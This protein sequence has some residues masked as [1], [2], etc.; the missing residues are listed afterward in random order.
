MARAKSS[1]A[2]RMDEVQQLINADLKQLGFKKSQR[3]YNRQTEPGVV[4]VIN[5]QMGRFE[6]PAGPSPI[7]PW[8]KPDMYGKFTVNLGIFVEEVVKTLGLKPEKFIS[9]PGCTIRRRLGSL[10][11]ADRRDYWWNLDDSATVIAQSIKSYL[12]SAGFEFLN[13]FS[14]RS[15]I[16]ADYI[17]YNDLDSNGSP[18][19]RLD[20]GIMLAAR[21]DMTGAKKLLR[22]HLSR[23]GIHPLHLVYAKKLATD[24]GIAL[25]D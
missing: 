19:A 22:E 10:I 7:P 1:F 16:I 17:S 21:G 20:V 6:P 14:S 12:F 11:N 25:E 5:F 23:P 2:L 9:A 3:T 8:M 13:R 4:Q 24:L 15:A 18:R